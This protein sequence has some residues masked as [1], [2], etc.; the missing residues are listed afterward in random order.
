[1]KYLIQLIT[2]LLFCLLTAHTIMADHDSQERSFQKNDVQPVL[3]SLYKEECGSCHFAY[4][5]SLLPGRS[6]AK[7]ISKSNLQNHFGE[8]LEI[9][10]FERSQILKYLKNNSAEKSSYRRSKKIMRQISNTE[11]PMRIS[12]TKYIKKKHRKIPGRLIAENS[13]VESL[14]NCDSCHKEADKGIFDDDTVLIP[15]Y[16]KWDDD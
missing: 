8:G 5:P 14:S 13:E 10:E 7:L 9:D 11:I 2:T 15:G 3:N 6:W 1:M 4:P 12:E 16:G